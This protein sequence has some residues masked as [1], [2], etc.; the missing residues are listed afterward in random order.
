[1]PKSKWI[2][3]CQRCLRFHSLQR[4]IQEE[5]LSISQTPLNILDIGAGLGQSAIWLASLGHH[6]TLSEPSADMLEI[7]K[8]NIQNAGLKNKITLLH[9]DLQTLSSQ[10]QE[11]YDVVICH[12]VLEWLAEPENAIAQLHALVKP[13][14]WLSL[15][16]YNQHSGIMRSLM[17][18]NIER[19]KNNQ[20]AGDGKKRLAPISPLEPTEVLSWLDTANFHTLRHSGVRCF[21]DHM[22]PEF[23]AKADIDDVIEMEESL[24]LHPAWIAQ[25]RYQHVI[26]KY[27]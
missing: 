11:T 5:I 7:A 10:A 2:F 22:L 6:V 12:A 17:V 1:M 26:C 20:L 25:A 18:G 15:M 9:S 24:S 19:V 13:Q 16:F 8:E 27:L 4:D 14:G 23:R 3:C 21:Y